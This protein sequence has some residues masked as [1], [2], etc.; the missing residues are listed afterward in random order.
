M[1]SRASSV[2]A[3]RSA[4]AMTTRAPE[5]GFQPGPRAGACSRTAGMTRGVVESGWDGVGV[6]VAEAGAAVEAPEVAAARGDGA[7]PASPP[8]P[9][10]PGTA[11]P[12]SAATVAV[13]MAWTLLDCL[14]SRIMHRFSPYQ[15]GTGN[16]AARAGGPLS[17]ERGEC[18]GGAFVV[19]GGG[20]A[21]DTDGPYEAALAVDGQ[22]MRR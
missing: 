16:G 21:A 20:S 18:G 1:R 7:A 14:V 12:T 2:R 22:S 5:A 6:G 3:V 11:R 17:H 13:A 8:P 19:L 4:G 15:R 9:A 10:H